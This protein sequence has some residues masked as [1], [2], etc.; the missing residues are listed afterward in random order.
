MVCLHC[1]HAAAA[2]TVSLMNGEKHRF[3]KDEISRKLT[4]AKAGT[5]AMANAG[6]ANT[7][8]SQFYITLRDGLEDQLDGKNTV[9]GEVV[10]GLEVLDVISN[11][12]CDDGGR[13]YI[14][15]RYVPVVVVFRPPLA[16]SQERHVGRIKHTLVIDD[17]TDDI[18]GFDE[19][20]PDESPELVRPTSE[21]GC[22]GMRLQGLWHDVHTPLYVQK[23]VERL[24]EGDDIDG[25]NG[26]TEEEIDEELK[27]QE[28]K[29]RAR[30][31]EIVRCIGIPRSVCDVC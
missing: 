24:Q 8:G 3:F 17:P 26:R 7:N 29:T 11:A 25:T 13:P 30:T 10:D 12:Y 4:H 6:T 9:F 28:A 18:P 16:P 15:I 5:V 1:P 22:C 14:D 31:L 20:C 21:V 2:S 19:M 27:R 23:V